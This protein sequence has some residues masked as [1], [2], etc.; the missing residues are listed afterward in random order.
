MKRI[1]TIMGIVLLA[2]LLAF[3]TPKKKNRVKKTER[4]TKTVSAQKK[5]APKVM[6]SKFRLEYQQAE[7]RAC[8]NSAVMS[9]SQTTYGDYLYY[10][11]FGEYDGWSYE[12]DAGKCND[13][14]IE[15]S[16]IAEAKD[17]YSYKFTELDD[18]DLTKPRWLVTLKTTEG[19]DYSVVEYSDGSDLLKLVEAA[20]KPLLNKVANHELMVPYSEYH[21]NGDGSLDYRTDHTAEGVVCGGYNA[22]DPNACF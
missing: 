2:G 5:E 20:F 7:G 11:G 3:A 15:L 1:L 19:K 17:L 9:L 16:R 22:K 6:L 14:M 8:K 4:T 12:F 21:Y 13:L 18:E 10:R